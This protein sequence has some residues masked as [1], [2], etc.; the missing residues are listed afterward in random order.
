MYLSEGIT[1]EDPVASVQHQRRLAEGGWLR[2]PGIQ[3]DAL[4]APAP[5]GVADEV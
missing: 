1:Q 4:E 3:G 2:W 5:V